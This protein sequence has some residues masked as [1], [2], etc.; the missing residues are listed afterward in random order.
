[1]KKLLALVMLFGCGVTM[2]APVTINFD[3]PNDIGLQYGSAEG[4]WGGVT[5]SG[6]IGGFQFQSTAAAGSL[7]GYLANAY[8]QAGVDY[9]NGSNALVATATPE[10][11]YMYFD[12]AITVTHA[13]GQSFA[14]YE[15]DWL[16]SEDTEFTGITTTGDI[17]TTA[18]AFGTG[19]WL[20]LQSFSLKEPS[21]YWDYG[22]GTSSNFANIELDSI[23]VSAVP[24]P[25]A[26]WLFGSGLGLLGWL[27]RR[28]AA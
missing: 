26:V 21:G 27:R 2:A 16:G 7:C 11:S 4:G 14:L 25:A 18:T 19:G 1:M 12:L 10:C 22:Y 5:A 13:T 8:T 15:A 23:T 9:R 3:E 28:Q 6:Q 24:V 17:V 20:N